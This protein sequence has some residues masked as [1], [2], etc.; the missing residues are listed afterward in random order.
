MS[1]I[2]DRFLSGFLCEKFIVLYIAE[3]YKVF[4]GF[5]PE[6]TADN[7]ICVRLL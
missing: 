4:Y 3:D 1:V 5:M 7:K 6:Y 2:D